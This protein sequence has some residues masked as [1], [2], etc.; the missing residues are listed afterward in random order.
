M[1]FFTTAKAVVAPF[2]LLVSVLSGI[3]LLFPLHAQINDFKSLEYNNS[4]LDVDLG[5]GLWAW[6]LPMDFDGD[7]DMDLL[8]SCPDKP[9]NGTYFFENKSVDNTGEVVFEKGVRIGEGMKNLQVS[10]VNDEPRVTSAGVEYQNFRKEVFKDPQTIY[11]KNE[12][13]K[14]HK[15]IRFSQWK[16][17]DYD[18]DGDQDV[19]V[20]IDDWADY[21][22]D[23]AFDDKGNWTNGPLRGFVYYLENVKGSYENRGKIIANGKP[24]DV[25]GAPSPNMYDFDNDGDLDLICGEFLDRLTWFENVGSRSNPVFAAGRFL[26]NARG[27]IK[28]DLEMIIPSAVDWDSDG[29]IDLIIGDEDGR[30]ALLLNT[31][32]IK[33][34]MPQFENPKYLKQKAD[35]VKFGALVTP[36]AVDWDDDGDEDLICGNSAGYIGFIENLGSSW[37]EPVYL[38]V[39]DK[40]VRYQAG[41]NGSIQGPAEAKWGYTTLSVADWDGDGLKDILVNSIWGRVE[42]LRNTGKKGEAELTNPQAVEIVWDTTS[43]PKPGWNWWSPMSNELVTQW[44]TTPYAIDWNNDGMMDLVMLDHQGYLTYFER[45]VYKG[46][47]KL[48]PGKR[49]FYGTHGSAFSNRNEVQNYDYGPLQLNT[50][51]AGSSGRRKL[52][53]ADWDKDGDLDLLVNGKNIVLFENTGIKE[54][55]VQMAFRGDVSE[56]T[57][58]GHTTSPTIIHL[59][60]KSGPQLLVGAEDGFLYL[61][62]K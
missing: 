53:F 28:M 22:W 50:G 8:V 27:L 48:R 45:F 49:I 19:L 9:S 51:I 62:D 56:Q 61:L 14:N 5:V 36:Y 18:G 42:W 46:S 44:R 58:A 60:K 57:L 11:D 7:G 52:C 20:G 37:A 30:V 12:L 4:K 38:T 24:I 25:Y 43:V 47:L 39:N 33:D 13:E 1:N 29:D 26:S 35:K 16:Y 32:R 6:P 15:K 31:G 3:S 23:N 41:E 21:G 10:F 40:P 2:F 55:K 59:N 54:H 34:N 17:V